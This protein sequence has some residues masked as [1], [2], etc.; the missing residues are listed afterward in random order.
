MRDEDHLRTM[1]PALEMA[2]RFADLPVDAIPGDD[3]GM[4]ADDLLANYTPDEIQHSFGRAFLLLLELERGNVTLLNLYADVS[5]LTDG[6]TGD[7]NV[8]IDNDAIRPAMHR[9]VAAVLAVADLDHDPDRN[10]SLDDLIGGSV[11]EI[12]DIVFER[13]EEQYRARLSYLG[14]ALTEL[15]GALV[16]C[17]CLAQLLRKRMTDDE[18]HGVME[19]ARR[20]LLAYDNPRPPD[21][22]YGM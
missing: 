10:L 16:A 13:V 8:L 4:W 11:D 17:K 15:C 6:E 21:S 14:N 12:I 9:N 18:Y 2:R 5:G 7:F 19:L 3:Y 22:R 1:L 20:G